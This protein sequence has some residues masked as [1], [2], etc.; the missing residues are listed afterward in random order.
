MSVE[1][2]TKY[3]PELYQKK[4]SFLDRFLSIFAAQYLKLEKN[5]ENIAR[6]FEVSEASHGILRWLAEIT[7]VDNS[8]LWSGEK[9]RTLLMSDIKK[10][11]RPGLRTLIQIYTSHEPYF[12]ESAGCI[13]VLIPD[14]AVDTP[15]TLNALGTLINGF[16]PEKTDYT[17]ETLSD[18]ITL[19]RHT[20]MG[21]NTRLSE[22]P[23]A[24]LND[25]ERLEFV[26]IGGQEAYE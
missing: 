26:T 9:L 23:T 13:T 3:L 22:F 6:V 8:Q 11:T 12:L 25:V 16:L 10:G 1:N 2:F 19:S 24:V 20:Y 5:V 14:S 18:T 21:I 7:Y 17:I 4:N 15:Q